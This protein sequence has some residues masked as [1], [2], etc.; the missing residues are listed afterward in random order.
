[1]ASN[2]ID[3]VKNVILDTDKIHDSIE[4]TVIKTDSSCAFDELIR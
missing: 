1:M 2:D 3:L 4:L